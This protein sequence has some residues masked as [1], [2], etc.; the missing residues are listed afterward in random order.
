MT[1]VCTLD[2]LPEDISNPVVTIGNFDGVH[3]GHQALFTKLKDRAKELKGT[4]LVITFEPHPIKVMS[5]EKLKPLITVLEQKKELVI[6]QGIDLLLLI[7]FTMKFSGIAARDFVKDILVDKIR[8]KE[9]IVG[10]DYAFGHNREGD[11][12]LL[13]DMG[14]EFDFTVTEVEPVYAGNTLVSSTSIRNLIL[15]GKISEANR[16]LGR[17]YQLMGEVVEGRRRGKP[18]LGYSTANLKLPEGLIP[19]EGVYIVTVE[20][21]GRLY[22]GLTNI[23][24]NPTFKNKVLS[25]ETHILDFSADIVSQNIKV[26]FLARLRDEIRFG[27]AEELSQQI[28]RDIEG[29]REFFRQ[30]GN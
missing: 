17:D 15:E 13:R 29:A 22:Q 6:S 19:R 3:K 20:L 7:K 10:Y 4:S 21:D 12:Q 9:I 25:I 2:S 5:P 16:L 23:G 8:I 11:I 24:Y 1:H 27:T 18:L 30:R 28:T 14:K 26:N